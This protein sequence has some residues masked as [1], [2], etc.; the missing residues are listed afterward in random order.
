MKL[1]C[2]FIAVILLFSTLNA[3]DYQ[4]E[5][6]IAN[7]DFFKRLTPLKLVPVKFSRTWVLSPNAP[8]D[9]WAQKLH[10]GKNFRMPENNLIDLDRF[11]KKTPE[12]NSAITYLYTE[13]TAPQDGIA[14]IGIGC[15][16]WFEAACNGVIY[17]STFKTGNNSGSY[18]P[19]NNPFF[20]PVKRGKNLLAVKLRRG[21]YTWS[22]ACGNVE[23]SPAPQVLAELSVGPWLSNPDTGEI[24]VRFATAGKLHGGVEFREA[25]KPATTEIKWNSLSGIIRNSDLH[26]VTLRGLTPGKAYEYRIVLLNPRDKS[27]IIYPQGDRF[28]RYNCP[29]ADKDTFSFLFMADL[30]FPI[31]RQNRIFRQL[32]KVGDFASCDFIVFGGDL[33]SS[34][35]KEDML[36]GLFSILS[37]S[38]GNSIPAVVVRGNHELTGPHPELYNEFFGNAEN[39]T[40]WIFRYGKAAFLN[41]DSFS[42]NP[43]PERAGITTGREFMAEQAGYLK[44]A[45]AS[46]KWNNAARRFVV[47]H[48]AP[49]SRDDDKEMCEATRKITDPY[50]AGKNPRSKLDLWLGAHTHRY[51]RSIPGKPEIAALQPH[52]SVTFTGENYTFPVIT[53]AG[54][55]AGKQEKSNVFRVDVKPDRV[56]VTALLPDGKCIEKIIYYNDGRVQEITALPRY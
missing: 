18:A 53:N 33:N 40:Y 7:R 17:H 43:N 31:E 29:S 23:F 38:G 5:F 21:S 10:A 47:S 15:D 52:K 34:F 35:V 45:L 26:S 22:F 27:K 14:Q 44:K 6:I 55:E 9:K 28:H 3:K 12:R 50:F 2:C 20:I 54:P 24:T 11:Y 19:S 42:Q 16:W 48:S 13:I 39:K 37:N 46:E 32:L 49:Y 36:N 1:S 41:F 30:Q 56:T 4:A 8:A 51:T 25:G